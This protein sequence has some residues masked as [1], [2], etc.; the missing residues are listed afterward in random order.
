MPTSPLLDRGVQGSLDEL[1]TPLSDVTFVVVDLETTGGRPEAEGITEIG[2]VKVRGG[3]VVGEFATLVNPGREIPVPIAILTGITTAMV[4][5]APRIAEVLPAFLEFLGTDDVLVAHNARFDV[6]FL[7]A[8]CAGADLTWPAPD[9]VD[10]VKLAR[11]LVTADEAPNHKLASL[12]ALFGTSTSPN[13]RA[14]ADARAT[15]D[16]LH[17]LL[18]RLGGLG[19]TSR[20]DL[21]TFSARVPAQRRRKATLADVLPQAPG[22]Y[23]FEDATGTPLYVGTSGNIRKRVKSYFTASEQRRR[24]AEMV[25]LAERVRPIVCAT[26]LE[27]HIREIR[28]IGEYRPRYNRRSTHPDRAAW[29]KVTNERYPRLSVVR[30]IRDDQATYI[31]PF[32]GARAATRA[33]DVVHSVRNIRQCTDRLTAKARSTACVLAD[34]N[35]CDAP[36]TGSVSIESYTNLVAHVIHE[37]TH[38]SA[39]LVSEA[40]RRLHRLAAEERF[41]EA[42]CGRDDLLDLV[43]GLDRAQRHA[44]V[45]AAEDLLAARPRPSGGWEFAL[46]RH[47]RL[48][49]TAACERS[50]DPRPTIASLQ[51][52]AEAVERPVPG[53]TA[54]LPEETDVLL[55]WLEQPGTR[56]V[57]AAQPWVMPVHGAPSD[58]ERL[59]P[60]IVRARDVEATWSGERA[61][62]S[63][64]R[65]NPASRSRLE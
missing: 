41:E 48:A 4:F 10:T 54:A 62:P 9:V 3:E 28:L 26:A 56:I 27:A 51:L 59:A 6:G 50:Q 14:L 8:A 19:V 55:R 43:V 17:A 38:D 45:L 39:S 60:L 20:E 44:S 1:G 42:R 21:L 12:A 65:S 47:G 35:R 29:L 16:V 52:S 57:E 2:A 24:M 7:K 15:V 33:R 64:P 61:Q 37:L 34:M 40:E 58:L 53:A 30:Q 63:R 32:I 5:E 23:V 49:G 22:V 18:G 25:D 31:G 46:I 11:A 13:H 36:C